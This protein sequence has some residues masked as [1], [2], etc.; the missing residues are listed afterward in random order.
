MDRNKRPWRKW[1]THTVYFRLGLTVFVV[2]L[3]IYYWARIEKAIL[4]LGDAMAPLVVGAIVAYAVNILFCFIER[5]YDKVF[6]GPFSQRYRKGICITC[7]YLLLIAIIV[8]VICVLV[9]QLTECLSLL[10]SQSDSALNHLVEFLKSVPVLEKYG[11]ILENKFSNSNLSKQLV[12]TALNLLQN[13]N[14]GWINNVTSVVQKVTGAAAS[15]LIGLVFSFY[16]LCNKET[17]KRQTVH[18][19]KTYLRGINTRV[20]EVL[21][22]F[23][24]SF[25]S[26]IVGQVEDACVLGLMCAVAMFI[27]RMPYVGM[28]AVIIAVTALVPIVGAFVGALV[29]FVLILSVSFSKALI[30]VILFIVVQQIDNNVTYPRIVGGS[31]GLPGIWVLAAVTIGGSSFGILGMLFFIPI[32]SSLYKLLKM[33]MERRNA[34]AAAKQNAN[35]EPKE[36][37]EV[38]M[39][40]E[41]QPESKKQAETVAP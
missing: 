25:R 3:L 6:R 16:V 2:Y 9:P 4:L 13:G 32:F 5:H 34:K 19:M 27:F 10:I 36:T 18:V 15:L 17:L 37:S 7:S 28:I 35:S 23:N 20:L 21:N 22:V 40:A 14:T 1:L 12:D 24:D 41:T 33:D 31:I 26:F 29:G 8:G 39:K 38:Q 30:F 11:V